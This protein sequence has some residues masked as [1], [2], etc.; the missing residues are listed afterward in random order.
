MRPVEETT[1]SISAQLSPSHCPMQSR[2]SRWARNHGEFG[3]QYAIARRLGYEKRADELLE[4]A[5][6]LFADWIETENGHR[7]IENVHV[8]RARLMI[9]TRKWLLWKMA[10]KVYG[11]H[12]T[13]AVDPDQPIQHVV[14]RIDWP[15][16]RTR[17]SRPSRRSRGPLRADMRSNKARE[18]SSERTVKR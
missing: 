15:R 3:C 11:D 16:R 9:D 18:R 7:V 8:N 5:D 17:R 6:D 13:V 10:A 4:I 14:H 1:R 2:Q 12:L